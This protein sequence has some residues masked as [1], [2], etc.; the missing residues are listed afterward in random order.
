MNR[1]D[2]RPLTLDALV[3]EAGGGCELAGRRD[4]L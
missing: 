2:P 4:G 1:H 3:V